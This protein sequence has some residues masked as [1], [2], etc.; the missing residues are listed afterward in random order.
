MFG[1]FKRIK[2]LEEK[3]VQLEESN[4]AL[5]EENKALSGKVEELSKRTISQTTTAE[6]APVSYSQIINEWLNGEEGTNG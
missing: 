1:I 4:T 5:R 2:R 6:D 3:V